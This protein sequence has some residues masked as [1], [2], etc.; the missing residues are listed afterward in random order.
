MGTYEHKEKNNV[1]IYHDVI[2][3]LE[4]V[5]DQPN[6][7]ALIGKLFLNVMYY[8]RDGEIPT[9][10]NDEALIQ[11]L[12]NQMKVGIDTNRKKYDEA[13]RRNKENRNKGNSTAT[14]SSQTIDNQTQNY[15]V[16]DLNMVLEYFL[17]EKKHQLTS[18]QGKECVKYC[19]ECSEH[20]DKP[21][22]ENADSW[23]DNLSAV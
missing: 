10:S 20:T 12:F 3:S 19:V 11:L 5:R 6:G 13:C 14:E 23:F 16:P 15:N 8:S 7:Y 21:W 9:F 4:I 17:L 18:A 1:L 2:P 22:K